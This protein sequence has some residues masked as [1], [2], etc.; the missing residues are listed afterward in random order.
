MLKIG[1]KAPDFTAVTDTGAEIS[2]SSLRGKKVVLYFYPRDD[3]PGC[4]TE[5]CDFRDRAEALAAKDAVV[6]GVST[7]TVASHEKFKAKHA[8]PFTLLADP[9]KEL[10]SAYGVYQEKK[11]YG[12]SFMGTVR[13]TFVIDEGGTITNVFEKVKVK[14]HADAVLASL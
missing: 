5:A 3:T 13:T 2:L 9:G 8:L 1:E 12:R 7:D 10:V 4:T 14:D 11:Q 6:L